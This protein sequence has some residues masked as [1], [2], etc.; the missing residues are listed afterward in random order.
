MRP[1]TII[2][3]EWIIFAT[4]ALG[5]LQSWIDWDRAI[6]MAFA[7]FVLTVRIF[8]F[9]V[10]AGLTL[11]VSRRR[12][13]VAMWILLALFALGIPI[14]FK[15]VSSGLLLGSAWIS[16][17]QLVGQLV[18]YGLLFTPSARLWRRGGLATG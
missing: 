3:F 6:Q 1:R 9:G 11:L 12:S 15:I 4:L 13:N 7:G 18:A 2:Y 8:T 16:A 17:L 5:V 10:I 14:F